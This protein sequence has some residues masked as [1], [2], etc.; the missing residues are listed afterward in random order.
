MIL[1]VEWEVLVSAA[2]TSNEVVLDGMNYTFSSIAT[3]DARR[4]SDSQCL[5]QSCHP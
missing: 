4:T 1:E 2:E 3:L 5:P